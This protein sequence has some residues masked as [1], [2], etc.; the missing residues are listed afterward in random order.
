MS[1]DIFKLE[2]LRNQWA[3]RNDI[4]TE[5]SLGWGKGCIR[6][7]ARSDRNSGVH[8]NGKLPLG[9]NGENVVTTLA[10]SFLIGSSSY[11]QLTRTSITSRTSSKFGQIGPRTTE[12][13]ALARLKN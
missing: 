3:N 7:W 13:S 8:G 4:L 5:P 11:L 2:Y 6:F 10:P 12:L 1:V 9:Y